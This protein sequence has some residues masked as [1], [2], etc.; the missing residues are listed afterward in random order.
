LLAEAEA[1]VHGTTPENVHFHEVGAVDS[2]TDIVA[3]QYCLYLLDIE[4]SI[5]SPLPMGHGLAHCAHGWIPIPAPATAKLLEGKPTYGG[6]REGELVTPT[7]AALMV[8]TASSFGAQPAMTVQAIGYGAGTREYPD[9]ANVARVFIGETE[10][11]LPAA[12]SITVLEANIDDMNPELLPVLI[13]ALMKEGARD[14]FCAPVTGKKGRVAYCVT[15]LSD[16]AS[17]H[18]L[19]NVLFAHS[20]TLGVRF[21]R[22]E[23]IVLERAWKQAQTPWGVVRVKLG[24][25][26][27]RQNTAAPEFDDCRA[28]AEAA[29]VPARVVYEMALAAAL[30]G[31]FVDG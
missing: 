14:A 10:S 12:E 29:N 18:A 2:I 25:F 5:C 21:H 24:S 22:E 23:R 17:V 6:D 8:Q 16:D 7:G 13:E 27:G 31:E 1:A 26:G 9:R 28:R 20:T 4:R 19:S 30:K 3:A 15:A 11:V